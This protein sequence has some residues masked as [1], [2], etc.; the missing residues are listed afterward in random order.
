MRADTG[1][2]DISEFKSGGSQDRRDLQQEGI[3]GG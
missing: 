1:P 2:K 3:T